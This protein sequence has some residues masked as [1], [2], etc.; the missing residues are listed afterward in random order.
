MRKYLVFLLLPFVFTCNSRQELSTTEKLHLTAKV[1]GF[2]K[3]YHPQVNEGKLN[4]DNELVEMIAKLDGVQTKQDLS[5]IYS[6]WID[7]LGSYLL[8]QL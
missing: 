7:S 1:W 8:R 4:W 6:G 2:L 3:Y 5:K